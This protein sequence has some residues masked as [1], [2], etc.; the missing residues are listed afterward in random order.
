MT[1]TIS[2][3]FYLFLNTLL[4]I[5]LH[6]DLYFSKIGLEKDLQSVVHLDFKL[7][8]FCVI[9]DN[10]YLDECNQKHAIDIITL[11]IRGWCLHDGTSEPCSTLTIVITCSV[12]KHNIVEAIGHLNSNNKNMMLMHGGAEKDAAGCVVYMSTT[13]PVQQLEDMIGSQ[14]IYT[15][16]HTGM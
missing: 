13:C 5:S 10:Q 11:W 3:S 12:A 1:T 7:G 8:T 15:H 14:R 9:F 4:I 16:T 6:F 2:P